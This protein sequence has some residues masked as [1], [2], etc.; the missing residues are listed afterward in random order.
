MYLKN[1]EDHHNLVALVSWF[2]KIAKI[3]GTS[4]DY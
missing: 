4:D 3:K 1:K 2:N